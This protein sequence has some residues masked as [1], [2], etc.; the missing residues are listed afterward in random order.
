MQTLALAS[1]H[2]EVCIKS[3]TIPSTDFCHSSL[4]LKFSYIKIIFSKLF[5][6]V[7]LILIPDYKV[8]YCLMY[9]NYI[10]TVFES[11]KTRYSL[12]IANHEQYC[13]TSAIVPMFH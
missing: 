9:A 11:I 7:I 10:N 3:S 5:T 2:R 8:I 12:T 13:S 1:I 4:T 6:I